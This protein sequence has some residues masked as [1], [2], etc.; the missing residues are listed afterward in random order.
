[1]ATAAMMMPP[2]TIS[3]TQLSRPSLVQ[4][5]STTVMMRAPMMVPRTPATPPERLGAADDD[6]GN[7]FEF[8][9]GGG[10][11]VAHAQVT[12][13]EH[14]R[15]A[16]A[17]DAQDVDPELNTFDSDAAVTCGGFVGADG[18]GV[19][20]EDGVTQERGHRQVEDEE[21]QDLRG[22]NRPEAGFGC[23]H[24]RGQPAQ[25]GGVDVVDAL[26]EASEGAE[27]AEGHDEG[28]EREA[29]DRQFIEDED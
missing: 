17:A 27:H 10:R 28:R 15:H 26:G 24:E 29:F 5:L 14:P 13:L 11:R 7:G 25:V 4:P 2:V 21:N 8:V 22:Q 19:A 6:G 16:R 18:E 20:A 12:E 1:M 9:A 23:G 3:W